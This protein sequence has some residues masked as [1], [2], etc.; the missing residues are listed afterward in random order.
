MT[1]ASRYLL[2][3]A[4]HV[5]AAY[6]A[7]TAPRSI[8]LTGSAADGTSDYYSDL[9]LIAYYDRLPT[10]DQLAAARGLLRVTAFRA[11]SDRNKEWSE[12]KYLLKVSM[13]SSSWVLPQ[14]AGRGSSRY[15]E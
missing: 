4:E 15:G 2:A 14:F 6:L 3:L 7:H 1:E 9:D 10:D 5:A 8:L 12:E 13:F 11:A